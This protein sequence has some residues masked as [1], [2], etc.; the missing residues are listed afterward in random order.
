MSR[1]IA[2]LVAGLLCC[3][4]AVCA[5]E[6]SALARFISDGSHLIE[7]ADGI[8]LQLSMTQGVPYRIFT[9]TEPFRLVVDFNELNWSG[10]R[11]KEF[12]GAASVRNLRA[13]VFRPGWSR[14]VLEL[15]QPMRLT[16]AQLVTK[17]DQSAVVIVQLQP[18]SAQD[19]VQNAGAPAGA[20]FGKP[21][22][23]LA[24]AIPKRRQTGEGALVVVLDPGHGGVDPGAQAEGV[25]EADLIL[26]FALELQELLIRT[27]EVKVVLT[28]DADV[29]VPLE[30]RVSIARQAG[31]DAF[32]SL[33]A[34]AL[35]AGRAS[36]AT[37][38]TLSE[39]ASD[40]A[41][42]K[43]AE[44]HDRADLLA[45]VDLSAQDDV[46]VGV[47]M[48]MART[49]T[50]HR[51]DMLA[52]ALVDGLTQTVTTH[53]R[54][55]LSAGFSVL[56]APD[57]PSVLVELGFLSSSRD[58]KN[59]LDPKWRMRAAEGIRNALMNW[60]LEDAAQALLLRK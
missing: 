36:G 13:G 50:A 45:G 31:A 2:I 46:V 23:S 27:G 21:S 55:R 52:D 20:T 34:D 54:P 9:L 10:L 51:S 7:D 26:T 15:S 47:L 4:S 40:L 60:A 39:Q 33:H 57:I 56:K 44:R 12:N 3:S 49:E 38:Y 25:V 8:D 30:A 5:R 16:S 59:L 6:L 11:P 35:V 58:R 32:I 42:Q 1:I 14:M 43:L 28:R 24:T 19:F 53:K 29:F 17:T 48:D 22:A 37:I 18:T 41:S